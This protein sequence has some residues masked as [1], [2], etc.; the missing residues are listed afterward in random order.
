MNVSKNKF[1]FV[2]RTRML[3]FFAVSKA[4]YRNVASTARTFSKREL[5]FYRYFL[6]Y[7]IYFELTINNHNTNL[8]R[9]KDFT[10]GS[11]SLQFFIVLRLS[12][13]VP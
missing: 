10:V 1:D 7:K 11:P 5:H 2:F 4:I 13:S 6:L 8:K 12:L 3:F 9:G